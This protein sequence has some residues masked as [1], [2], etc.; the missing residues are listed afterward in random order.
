MHTVKINHNHLMNIK[1][2]KILFYPHTL[3]DKDNSLGL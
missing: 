1:W 2:D 3:Y